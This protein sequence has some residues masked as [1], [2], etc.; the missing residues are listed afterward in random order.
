M[1]SY[2]VHLF[3]TRAFISMRTA[4]P[5]SLS[6]SLVVIFWTLCNLDRALC[7][8]V[9]AAATIPDSIIAL[10]PDG[11]T[12]I[13]YTGIFL[14]QNG[15]W[16]LTQ[17]MTFLPDPHPYE[18]PFLSPNLIFLGN[19]AFA[20]QNT[21]YCDVFSL[22][23]P[24]VDIY[25][26][27]SSEK[28]QWVVSSSIYGLSLGMDGGCMIPAT[29]S[30]DGDTFMIVSENPPYIV[31]YFDPEI[32][33]MLRTES[34]YVL[35]QQLFGL[36]NNIPFNGASFSSDGS[37][38]AILFSN[39][40]QCSVYVFTRTSEG[41]YVL[42]DELLDIQNWQQMAM[43]S[44]G[45]IIIGALNDNVN[46]QAHFFSRVDG[47]YQLI[48]ITDTVG[49]TGSLTQLRISS[50][51]SLVFMALGGFKGISIFQ[52]TT[53][54]LWSQVQLLTDPSPPPPNFDYQFPVPYIFCSSD[55]STLIADAYTDDG[56][57][58]TYYSFVFS[59]PLPTPLVS[60]TPSPSSS[61]SASSSSSYS[62]TM[63]SLVSA[64]SSSSA[65]STATMTSTSSSISSATAS[66]TSSATTTSTTTASSTSS[67]TPTLTLSPSA[68][69]TPTDESSSSLSAFSSPA[70]TITIS[71]LSTSFILVS[72]ALGFVWIARY[73]NQ[74]RLASSGT[75]ETSLQMLRVDDSSS[76]SGRSEPFLRV[77]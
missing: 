1:G 53:Q 29:A 21:T 50:D 25:K 74:S 20:A 9:P 24:S 5:F 49:A 60:A 23:G 61:S 28:D 36:P 46:A 66:S 8:W 19:D 51:A 68:S 62:A 3:G 26:A 65:T 38:L 70:V 2:L 16:I 41:S 22:I 73:R 69:A 7:Q 30:A 27:T 31:P 12:A 15:S 13:G 6:W 18:S 76:S 34:E 37:I 57:S 71:V 55:G 72:I 54:T 17:A 32:F 47:R 77:N 56:N 11:S 43:S 48:S 4:H 35:K 64:S 67:T 33:I 14:Q 10:S 39:G 45:Q 52:Q 40:D 42:T 44:N 75:S 58:N 63:S 59:A